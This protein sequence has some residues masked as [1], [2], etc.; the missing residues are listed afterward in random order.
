[1]IVL[2]VILEILIMLINV[3]SLSYEEDGIST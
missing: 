1:M 2:F 3:V